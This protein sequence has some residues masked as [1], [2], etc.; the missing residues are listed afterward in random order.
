MD[1]KS[2]LGWLYRSVDLSGITY[3]LWNNILRPSESYDWVCQRIQVS[4]KSNGD[5]PSLFDNLR[6]SWGVPPR[7]TF[8]QDL[9]T[10][11]PRPPITLTLNPGLEDLTAGTTRPK[12]FYFPSPTLDFPVLAFEQFQFSLQNHTALTGE[13]RILYIGCFKMKQP[14]IKEGYAARN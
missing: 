8:V 10:E 5:D 11:K 2:I 14:I 7:N 9:T 4:Y 1:N 3:S 13:L 6:W 12:E